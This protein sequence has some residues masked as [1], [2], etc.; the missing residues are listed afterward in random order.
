MKKIDVKKVKKYLELPYSFIVNMVNDES[1]KY[2]VARVLE[3]DGLIGIGDTYEGA[4]ID[5]KKAME[6][7]V[8]TKIANNVPIPKPIESNEY[9]GKF[10]LRLPKSLHKLLSERAKNEGVS[11]NQYALYKLSLVQ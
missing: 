3:L 2:Y 1:G 10:V 4:I 11:L 7:Y 8:E 9:S 6:S 5:L